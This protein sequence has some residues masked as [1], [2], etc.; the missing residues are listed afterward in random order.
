MLSHRE[1]SRAMTRFLRRLRHALARLGPGFEYFAMNEWSEGHQ[2][3][4]IVVR[5]GGDATQQMIRS[6]WAKTLPG[7]QF[8]CHCDRVRSAVA[9]ANYLVKNLKDASKKEL[10]PESFKGRI[11]TCSRHFFTKPIATLWKEQVQEWF[12]AT[13]MRPN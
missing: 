1:L 3:T 10:P 7:V 11:F 12:P 9:M 6:L 13:G 2:H 5:A 4:H 8:T